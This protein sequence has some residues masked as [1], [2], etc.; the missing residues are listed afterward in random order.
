MLN[1]TGRIA[2]LEA[3]L[4]KITKREGRFSRD[5]LEHASNT[6]EAMAFV[7]DGALNG[8]WDAEESP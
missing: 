7:A 3:A 1:E 2:Y 8:T 4:R 5:R 6:I